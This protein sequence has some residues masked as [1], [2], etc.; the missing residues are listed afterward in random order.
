[1]FEP[2]AERD[3]ARGSSAEPCLPPPLPRLPHCAPIFKGPCLCAGPP[4]YMVDLVTAAQWSLRRYLLARGVAARRI[5]LR[6]YS[7]HAYEVS[8]TGAGPPVLLLHGLGGNANG[9]FR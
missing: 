1:M 6:G 4:G 7:L 2:V 5:T 9:F 8:G 3:R